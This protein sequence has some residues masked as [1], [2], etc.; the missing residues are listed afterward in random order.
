MRS[1]ITRFDQD[2][3]AQQTLLEPYP[4]ALIDLRDSGRA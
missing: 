4:A 1:W 2:Y 3:L